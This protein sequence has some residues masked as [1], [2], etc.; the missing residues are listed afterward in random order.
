MS[1]G[2][3][4][5]NDNNCFIASEQKYFEASHK[6]NCQVFQQVPWSLSTC[7]KNSMQKTTK[8]KAVIYSEH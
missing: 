1:N 4:Q 3:K 6:A 2:K 8:F 5:E 7:R